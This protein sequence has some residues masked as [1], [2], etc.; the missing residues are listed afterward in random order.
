MEKT[1]D[2]QLQPKIDALEPALAQTWRLAEAEEPDV[3][4]NRSLTVN[5][6]AVCDSAGEAEMMA[7][8]EQVLARHPSRVFLVVVD[9]SHKELQAQ[10]TAKVQAQNSCRQMYLELVRLQTNTAD[11]P[12]LHNL[13]RPL[14][15]N[16]IPIQLFWG[17]GLPKDM[18]LVTSLADMA[19]GC[20]FDST[21]FR[22]DDWPRLHQL[23]HPRP[24]DLTYLR[25]SPWR[26]SLA[27]AFEHFS[28]QAEGPVCQVRLDIGKG[29]GALAAARSLEHWLVQKLA[30]KVQIQK[31]EDDL[32]PPCQP[33]CL[34]LQYGPVHIGI[35]HLCHSPQL[36]VEI[37][38]QE[39]CLLPYQVQASAA[40]RGNLLAAALDRLA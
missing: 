10:I 19:A 24:M 6:I 11:Y 25:L 21:L 30:A 7:A 13:I 17:M 20:I 18:Q 12:K 8:L 2:I 9:D 33:L 29:V 15:V 31:L 16:D 37:T 26:R 1:L 22:G 4:L 35:R 34:D 27:E 39:Q 40:S 32:A 28:W 38:L 23:Q 14:L 5:F 3:P 36:Q